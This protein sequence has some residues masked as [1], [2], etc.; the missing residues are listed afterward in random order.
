MRHTST[1]LRH[2]HGF[3]NYGNTCR[4]CKHFNVDERYHEPENGIYA[5][6]CMVDA[7]YDNPDQE[8]YILKTPWGVCDEHERVPVR[9]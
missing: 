3:V 6:N 2:K 7:D 8:V 4:N 9:G 1:K 5:Y